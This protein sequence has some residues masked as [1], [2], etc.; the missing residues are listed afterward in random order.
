MNPEVRFNVA[1]DY[2]TLRAGTRSFYYGYEFGEDPE[3]PEIWGFEYKQAG[4]SVLR[5]SFD[6]LAA[7][8]PGTHDRFDTIDCLLAGLGVVLS[9]PAL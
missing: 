8:V 7:K 2:A 5:L 1:S 6:E 3:G 4:E 9:S